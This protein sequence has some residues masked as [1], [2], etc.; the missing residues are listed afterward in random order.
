MPMVM[1]YTSESKDPKGEAA[2]DIAGSGA[3]SL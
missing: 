3:V 2:F 1:H